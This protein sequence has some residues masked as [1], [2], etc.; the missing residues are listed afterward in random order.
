MSDQEE[1][2]T[3]KRKEDSGLS[4]TNLYDSEFAADTW[5]RAVFDTSQPT[6]TTNG[7]GNS[8]ASGITENSTDN[9]VGE[10]GD[11]SF[12]TNRSGRTDLDDGSADDVRDHDVETASEIA[13]PI[14]REPRRTVDDHEEKPRNGTSGVGIAGLVMSILSLFLWPYLLGAVGIVLGFIA[15]RRNARTLGVWAMVI[16]AIAILGAL[17]IFP[18][19]TAR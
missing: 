8:P 11:L 2:V 16:G 17:I 19:Y 6:S 9:S 10:E 12:D 14:R 3:A 5:T 15:Y 13:E 7:H 4:E 1:R 18:Y